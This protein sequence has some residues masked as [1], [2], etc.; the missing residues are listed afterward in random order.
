MPDLTW[1]TATIL[2]LAA[3]RLTLLVTTDVITDGL[4]RR[5]WARWP[6]N[7][8]LFPDDGTIAQ[9]DDDKAYGTTQRG[10]AV[11]WSD[12]DRAWL[13][14]TPTR[15]G[16]LVNC[17]DCAGVWVSLVVV[18]LWLV[19]PPVLVAWGVLAA[20]GVVSILARWT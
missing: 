7:D 9:D 18:G 11:F 20:A 13:A 8:T 3:Y 1:L 15:I 16:Y 4:R 14:V 12:E 2:G 19:W 10:V 5:V 17:N 6:A